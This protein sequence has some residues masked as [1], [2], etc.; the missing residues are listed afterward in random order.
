[1][2]RQLADPPPGHTVHM[3]YRQA[4]PAGF[5]Y[6]LYLLK[7]GLSWPLPTVRPASLKP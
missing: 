7:Y 3:Q 1:M 6:S 5:T 2:K 4:L